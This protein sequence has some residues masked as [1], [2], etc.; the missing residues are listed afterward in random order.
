MVTAAVEIA[1]V[2]TLVCS[3]GNSGQDT[4]G[5][6]DKSANMILQQDDGTISLSIERASYYQDRMDPKGNTAEWGFFVSK[7]G[8]YGVWLSSATI[9]TMNLQY[10]GN[11]IISHLDER[12]EVK[13]VGNKIITNTRDVTYPYFRADSYMG[14]FYIREPGEHYIQLI[15]DRAVPHQET[16][17]NESELCPTKLM[18]VILTPLTR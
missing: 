14:S 8:R 15:S 17:S 2:L 13:P 18:S 10:S 5:K 1:M 12:L 3:C 11:V 4:P 7:P 16:A 6:N 9:D